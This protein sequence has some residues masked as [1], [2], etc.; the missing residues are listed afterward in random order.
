M[1]QQEIYLNLEIKK[2]FSM[3]SLDIEYLNNE[4]KS[5]ALG[6]GDIIFIYIY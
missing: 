4:I 1:G 3:Y 6:I 5:C 2:L